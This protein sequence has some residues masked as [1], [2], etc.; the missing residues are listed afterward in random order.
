[1]EFLH[2]IALWGRK[3]DP[4]VS[5]RTGSLSFTLNDILEMFNWNQILELT[6]ITDGKAG[7]TVRPDV[8]KKMKVSLLDSGISAIHSSDTDWYQLYRTPPSGDLSRVRI[9]A[10]A[11]TGA[12]LGEV[13][14]VVG[15][16]DYSHY[17]SEDPILGHIRDA[18]PG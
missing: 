8:V 6:P 7:A 3:Y 12:V 18:Q 10:H 1:M 11:P 17:F 5:P 2:A 13:R 16:R 9:V 14:M 15:Q 4:Q